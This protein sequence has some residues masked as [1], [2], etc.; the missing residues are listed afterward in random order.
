MI[1]LRRPARPVQTSRIETAVQGKPARRGR[2][3]SIRGWKRLRER[4]FKRDQHMCRQ[5]R[6]DGILR[7]LDLH[8]NDPWLVGYCDHYVPTGQGGSDDMSN[9][10]MLCK[11]CHDRKTALEAKGWVFDEVD[12]NERDPDRC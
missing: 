6:A 7:A 5:C 11:T 1:R 4:V 3:R 12:L 2:R 8:N 9:L 10:W